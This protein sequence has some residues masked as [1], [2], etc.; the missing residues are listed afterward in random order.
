MEDRPG[1]ERKEEERDESARCPGKHEIDNVKAHTFMTFPK[2]G[3]TISETSRTFS[4]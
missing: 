1:E 3:L 2:M 4:V